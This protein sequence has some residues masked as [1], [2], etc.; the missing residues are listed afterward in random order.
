MTAS[1]SFEVFLKLARSTGECDQGPEV[2]LRPGLLV[3]RYDV[4]TD[5]G[6]VWTTLRFGGAIALRVVPE[7][8]VSPLTVSAYSK[9]GVIN[10]SEW[11][12]S[13][14]RDGSGIPGDL[15][16]F[17]V[18]FDHYGSVETLARSCEVQS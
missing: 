16:H 6:L 15:K 11:L 7:L 5:D 13:L 3:V 10:N 2:L 9:V 18:F 14:V 17:I 12:A 4:E 1:E 8:A